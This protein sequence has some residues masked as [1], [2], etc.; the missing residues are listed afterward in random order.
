MLSPLCYHKVNLPYTLSH[1]GSFVCVVRYGS[2]CWVYPAFHSLPFSFGE[3]L[4]PS[5]TVWF[6][7]FSNC[8]T[9]RSGL[10]PMPGSLPWWWL[11]RV[12]HTTEARIIGVQWDLISGYWEWEALTPLAS[13]KAWSRDSND[14]IK[15]PGSL[16]SFP[17]HS[18]LSSFPG[19]SLWS[20]RSN[21]LLSCSKCRGGGGGSIKPNPQ[22]LRI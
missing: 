20:A 1:A 12:G 6:G 19:S 22:D 8:S 10:Y 17:L 4:L 7:F 3:L 21:M 16:Y 14:V 15:D 2:C 9:F 18:V 11:M 13:G 5:P